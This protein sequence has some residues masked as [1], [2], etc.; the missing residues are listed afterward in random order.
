MWSELISILK[1]NREKNE[2]IPV[3]RVTIVEDVD[4]MLLCRVGKL[5]TS[6]LGLPLGASFKSSRVWDVVKERFRKTLTM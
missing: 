6:H 3:R 5:P 1:A 4:S 2:A